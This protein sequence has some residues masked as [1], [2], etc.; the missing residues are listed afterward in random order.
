MTKLKGISDTLNMID[1]YD[2]D[3]IYDYDSNTYEVPDSQF[4]NMLDA[5]KNK[6]YVRRLEVGKGSKM[7][8][9]ST[10]HATLASTD[11]ENTELVFTP[12]AI[13]DLLS[14]VDEFQDFDL[15]LT[16]SL[17]G[18]LQLQ[19]GDSFYA[20]NSEESVT[21]VAVEDAVVDEISEINEST[22]ETL[23]S[24]GMADDI[25]SVESGIIKETLK[26]LLIGGVVRLGKHYLT[27]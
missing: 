17:D 19:V 9:S 14:Q 24:D 27:H 18:T 25:E 6:D 1:K 5:V 20:L 26:T 15:G 11:S 2:L 13:L 16:E 10:R 21:D 3:Y 12:A 22:Y 7:R 8:N 4:Q 23:I